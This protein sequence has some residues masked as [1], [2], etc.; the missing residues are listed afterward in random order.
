MKNIVYFI[1]QRE[2]QGEI[3]S[4]KKNSQINPNPVQI[5]LQ[6]GIFARE[7]YNFF[8]L[9][10]LQRAA[11]FPRNSVKTE[12]LAN[13]LSNVALM[14]ENILTLDIRALAEN[15]GCKL[16][17][18]GNLPYNISSQVL[19]QLV[20]SRVA[21]HRAVL[22]LQKELALRITAQP[23]CRDY[24][25]LSV[26][27]GYCSDIRILADVRASL[28]F[29]KPKVDSQV[30]EIRFKNL[31]EYPVDNEAFFSK[32]I[33]AG[34]GQRRKTLRNALAGSELHID[35]RMAN[36]ALNKAGIDPSRRA[37]TL[38]IKEFVALSNSLG[39]MS[40]S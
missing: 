18:M 40:C 2:S 9:Q 23:G 28:F 12:L 27:L 20:Q 4:C 31:P 26:M 13:T 37:E 36:D 8:K 30:L 16:I 21:V 33:K 6:G 32:V 29:P 19:V 24:G 34:F 7:L 14:E 5:L 25:R 10:R 15:A 35:A 11:N 22:M 17:V 1:K 39:K 3:D 38:D